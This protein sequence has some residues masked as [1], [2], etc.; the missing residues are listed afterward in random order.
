MHG[1]AACSSQTKDPS[2]SATGDPVKSE[3]PAATAAAGLKAVV[4]N[5]ALPYITNNGEAWSGLDVDLLKAIQ[6]EQSDDSASTELTSTEV[7]CVAE[8]QDALTNGTPTSFV[9]L[10]SRGNDPRKSTQRFPLPWAA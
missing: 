2:S 6:N 4:I 1:L 8:A 7:S 9:A 3:Q 10:A 5:V